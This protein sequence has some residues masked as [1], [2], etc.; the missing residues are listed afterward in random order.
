MD[1]SLEEKE[2][3][4]QDEIIKKNYDKTAFLNFCT[5]KK[6][7]GDDLNT[8]L[9]DEH[10]KLIDEFKYTFEQNKLNKSLNNVKHTHNSDKISE[11]SDCSNNDFLICPECSSPIEIVSLDEDTNMFEF[12]CTK[13]NHKTNIISLIQYFNRIKNIQLG[14][15][16]EFKD[17]CEMHKDN[18]YKIYCFDCERHLC[19]KCL[20]SG[21]HMNHTKNYIEEIESN[22]ELEI[23]SEI[24]KERKNE[25]EKLYRDKNIEIKN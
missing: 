13:F 17:K 11:I 20:K 19:K 5:S 16:N 25:L 7:K 15:L 3:L 6:E 4:I 12:E 18:K 24:I 8:L 23:I 1:K 9:L 14:D 21:E 2:A 22:Q 10:K